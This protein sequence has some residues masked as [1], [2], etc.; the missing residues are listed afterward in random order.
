MIPVHFDRLNAQLLGNSAQ[1]NMLL[2]W[3]LTTTGRGSWHSY[4]LDVADIRRLRHMIR[5]LEKAVVEIVFLKKLAPPDT[6]PY[7]PA[8]TDLIEEACFIDQQLDLLEYAAEK[9][10]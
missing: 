4:V 9:S 6:D 8:Q 3:P 10:E 5:L 2:V 1:A 7:A